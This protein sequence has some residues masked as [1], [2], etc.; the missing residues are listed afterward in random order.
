MKKL[1]EHYGIKFLRLGFFVLLC[2][3]IKP[4]IA[5][6]DFASKAVSSG[7]TLGKHFLV[8]DKNAADLKIYDPSGRL[9]AVTPVLLGYAKGDFAAPGVGSKLIKDIEPHEKTTPAGRFVS[10]PG[11][12]LNGESIVW[13]DYDSSVSVHRLRASNRS[14]KRVER[15]STA[16]P[17]DNRITY[18]CVNVPEAFYD[19]WIAPSFG[20]TPG[21][22]YV[23]P[24]MHSPKD[25]FKFLN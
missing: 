3:V 25:F 11:V 6:A 22:V 21:V 15:L 1:S 16:T 13:L 24:E 5:D 12:N 7:D 9:I 19:Q 10:E 14:E 2:F 18:G 8:I 23:L 17:S 4:G 20:R